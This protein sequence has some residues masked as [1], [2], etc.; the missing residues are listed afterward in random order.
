[1]TRQD[2]H[3]TGPGVGERIRELAQSHG[4]DVLDV[5]SSHSNLP[6]TFIVSTDAGVIAI[7]IRST[8][9]T[10]VEYTINEAFGSYDSVGNDLPDVATPT[11]VV[12]HQTPK[13]VDLPKTNP[14]MKGSDK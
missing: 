7:N 6:A 5:S 9:P 3:L 11:V 1:M 2:W 10:S 4:I 12:E 8:D 13:H 14:K